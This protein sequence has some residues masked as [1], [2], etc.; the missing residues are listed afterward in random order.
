[1]TFPYLNET[2]NLTDAVRARAGGSFIRLSDGVCHY[3]I[4]QHATR[5][6]PVVLIHGFSVPYFIWDPTF[7]FLASEPRFLGETGVLRVLRF[8]L[9][10]RGYSDRPRLRYDIHL[11][12]R[13]LRDL[14]DALDLRE[15]VTLV[16]LSMGGPVSAA[17]LEKYP[18]R[19]AKHILV[20]PAGA[21]PIE[22]SFMLKLAKIPIL[23]DLALGLAGDESLLKGIASDFYDP[24]LVEQFIDRYRPQMRIKGFKRAILST[25]RNNMLG[26][27]SET[28][29]RVGQLKKPTLLLW[30]RNDTTVPFAHSD[31]LRALLP[32]AEFHVIENVGHIPHYE[33]PGEVNPI[34][35]RFLNS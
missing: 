29:R 12:V 2:E 4:T 24:A 8:D 32:H 18:E 7:A 33:K 22:L 30:G 6:T 16:G 31:L 34:L 14:L 13:Q 20:D 3:E 10:G 25:L 15:P 23:S 11:F 17:F 9:F 26:D 19:V 5:T 28:Y 21:K 1:M 35:L 27:F